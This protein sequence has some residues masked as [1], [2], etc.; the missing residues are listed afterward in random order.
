MNPRK[1]HLAVLLCL[2]LALGACGQSSGEQRATSLLDE[3]LQ[4]TLA[5]DI[6]AGNAALQPLQNGA[7]VTLLGTAQYPPGARAE[8]VNGRDVRADVV[9]GLL[10]P[11]LIRIQVG[12]TSVLS[13]YQRDARV[14]DMTQYLQTYGLEPTLQPA[15]PLQSAAPVQVVPVGSAGGVP[16]GLTITISVQCPD[17]YARIDRESDEANPYCH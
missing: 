5:P 9:E 14:R 12:D 4:V 17:H 11:R 6:A 15:A 8:D 2:L 13:D 3:R 16:A 10:D 7:Q 1:W